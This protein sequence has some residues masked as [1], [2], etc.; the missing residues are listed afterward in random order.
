VSRSG[1]K[2]LADVLKPA[3]HGLL[4]ALGPSHATA[5]VV[6]TIIG[7]GIFR[8]PGAMMH[9]VGSSRWVYLS[10][11]VGGLLS[12]FGALAFAELGAMRPQS[13]G[14]YVYI[15]D[16]YGPLPGFLY[17][18]NWFVI[19][20]PASIATVVTGIVDAL[21]ALPRFGF[22][23]HVIF[24]RPFTLTW[25]QVVAIAAAVLI[26]G[27]NYVGIKR[28][29]T[30]QLVFT[31]M[32]VAMLVGIAL[33]GFT[34]ATGSWSNFATTT[35][36]DPGAFKGF[37]IALVAALWAYDGWNDL[38]MVG[39]EVKDP[40]RSIPIALI[41]GV[42]IVGVLYALMNAGIQYVLPAAQLAAAKSP[43]A[44]MMKVVLGPVGAAVI[45]AGIALSMLV[46]LNGTIMSGARIPFAV[47]R[48]GYFFPKLAEVHPKFRTP[49][50]AIIVQL[51]LA[52]LLLLAPANFLNFL[53]LA[54]F[55]E[56]LF[57]MISTSTLFVFRVR[58]PNA[59]RPYKTW[60]YPVVPALFI[61][62]AA[63][64]LVYTFAENLREAP[65]LTWISVAFLAAG[66]P[67][68]YYFAAQRKAKA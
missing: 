22:L 63:V 3:E 52:I 43:A 26:S 5:I 45:T 16:A 47:A 41:L 51:I 60:G 31:I 29:G 11:L 58:E 32:K 66:V 56:W 37:M 14:E 40:G 18:W 24:A 27:L 9:A 8:V 35:V 4:R 61:L 57:Y 38:N 68:F 34:Y 7:S 54:I 44:E 39:E 21:G 15:R 20:K 10:W 64:L 62:A 6:G 59:P 50:P 1:A 30:F 42:A 28:A 17:C 67:V 53:G 46:T 49:G 2:K 48:D 13:G 19:A 65:V 33:V 36:P 23:S 55:A 12:F 25:A